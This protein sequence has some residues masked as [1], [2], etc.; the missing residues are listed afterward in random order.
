MIQP[1]V[2]GVSVMGARHQTNDDFFFMN[3]EQGIYVICDGVSEGGQGKLA[4][5][6]TAKSIQEKLVQ[7]NAFLKKNGAQ[8]LGPKRLQSMQDILLKTF[9]DTQESLIRMAETNA[10][11]KYAA[12]TC[13]SVW[14]DGRFAILAHVGDSR[15]YLCRAGKVYQLTKDH[16]GLDELMKMG[17]SFEAAMK[18]PMSRSLTRAFGSAQYTHPDLLKIEF[19]PNDVLLLCTDGVYTAVQ[20]PSQQ[21]FFQAISQG[22]DLKPLAEKCAQASG[23]DS[24]MLEISF[25]NEIFRE[26]VLQAADRIKLIQQTPLSKYFDYIQKSHIAAICD[27]EEFKKGSI[28]V[29]EGT[30][31]DSMYIVAKGTL[32]ILLSGSHLTYKQPGEFIGE[33]G[34]VQQHSKRT[35]TVVAKEDTVLLSLKRSDLFQAFQKDPEMEKHFYRAMLEMVMER[36]L[37]QGQQIAQLRKA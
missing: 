7:G 10:N 1:K 31:G 6:A 12:T 3:P 36:M 27:I 25:P 4:S 23:D 22:Q 30:E 24:T 37:E 28:V 20:G 13:I 26:S 14:L 29:Q 32:E 16:S 5:E 9:S 33:V 34:L 19:Q 21:G 35:A 2:S 11:Y 17:L 18:N 8:L 15:A